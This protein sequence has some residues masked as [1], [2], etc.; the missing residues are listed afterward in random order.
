MKHIYSK[1]YLIF[2][3]ILF[4]SI[5]VSAQKGEN[6]WI[7]TTNSNIS[8]SKILLEKYEPSNSVFYKL[9]INGLKSILK[10][11]PKRK[12]INEVSNIILSFP[13]ENG[14][15]ESFRIKEAS[16]MT[17][18]LQAKFPNIRSYSGQGIDNPSAIIRFSISP[19]K[20][21]SSMVLS[22]KKTV[23]IEPYTNDLSTY[24]IFT[25][26]STDEK[27]NFV[28]ETES[29]IQK[30]N[31]D[32][33]TV[34][35][36][37]D[38]MLR[39]FRL[40]LACTGE[41]ATF[42]GGTAAGA[43]AGMNAT[44]TR[45][46]GLYERD[47]ALTMLMVDN[48]SIIFLDGA[49]DPYTNNSGGAMLGENQTTID[50]N[51]GSANYD[52]GHV[53]STSGGGVAFL[54]SACGGSKAGGV[55]G[56]GSPTGD[57]FDVDF[58]A[59]EFGHQYG[60]NHTQNNNCQRNNPT[61]FEP[62]SASTI[63]GYAGICVPNVQN[64]SDDYFHDASIAEMWANITT[65]S[66]QCA[67]QSATSNAAPV[68]DAGL[69]YTIPRSTPFVLNGAGSDAD[70]GNS[71]TYAWDQMDNTPATMPPVSTSTVGPAFRSLQP[72]VSPDRYMPDFATVLGGATASTWEVVPSVGRTM[73]FSLTV[74]DNVS[75]GAS[76]DTDNMIVT[77]ED[78]VPF[79][80]STPPTWEQG[81]MQTVS[82][83]VGQTTNGT[84]NCQNV[85]ILFS[86]DGGAN[87]STTLASNTPNDGSQQI[88]VPTISDT[89]NAIILVEAADNIFYTIS[90]VF[91]VNNTPDFAFNNTNGD[92][93][94]CNIDTLVYNFDFI[95]SNG[96]SETTTF[97]ATG[98]P[99]GSSVVFTPANLNSDGSFTMDVNGLTG[100]AIGDYTITV[101][102]TSTS[103]TKD[104]DVVLSVTGLCAS[105]ANTTFETSTT[106]VIFN[107]I[108]N[109]NT[110][111]PSGYSDYTAMST[112]VNR[113]S[114]Y[115]LT[116]NVNTDGNFLCTT[117][118][119]IDWNQNC[120]FDDAGEEYNLGDITNV[121]NDPTGN[122]PL[123]ITIP[124]GALLGNTIMRV[125]T[126]YNSAPTSCENGADAEVE[127]YT[128]NVLTTL[129]VEEN[130]FENFIVY[131]NPN[132]GEFT[133]KLN[134]NSGNNVKIVVY[135]IRGRRVF[136]STYNDA[137]NFNEIINLGNVQS[138]IYLLNVSDGIRSTT[139]KIVVN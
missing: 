9:D 122:S 29:I 94:G 128:V 134:S 121:T 31:F 41:Y 2:I 117:R 100:A 103:I 8:K 39:T 92:Q 20:G 50:T 132:N 104:V 40:A 118:V 49:T 74:R 81:S 78:V 33:V 21:L 126:K 64:N 106:G 19:E 93:S 133:V 18:D 59:H 35:N 91:S 86:S 38:G 84:I 5:Y 45:V 120:S 44:M 136:D 102:G 97:S 72:K 55:T 111:K 11:A 88:T 73:N 69:D 131:P 48:T 119:W 26:S 85:N 54:A 4:F 42:H 89:N 60:A 56:L 95:T 116:V 12:K 71:L 25:R 76:T 105:V 101:T 83:V 57:T 110:G 109:L 52:I 70:A 66:S 87:F 98:N 68:A 1:F 7:K 13:T 6:L 96:F 107:T 61:A 99:V 53:F 28:C 63:M 127:D 22:N 58:V 27:P 79:T 129:S 113:E 16:T 36:A 65:G 125:S 75:G 34:L 112:D 24:K 67:A 114:I 137:S 62:G 138:G 37:N 135:D 10:N 14:D 124:A 139:K 51:I 15:F 32:N 108:S 90:S 47:L 23:F 80:V 3:S 82:W 130:E 30:T 43:L 123:A 77:V 115:N 46:N 17:P